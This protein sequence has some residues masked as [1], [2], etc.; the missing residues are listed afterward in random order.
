PIGALLRHPV[1]AEF[2]TPPRPSPPLS[3]P[4]GEEAVTMTVEPRRAIS[5]GDD[6]WEREPS[7]GDRA[8]LPLPQPSRVRA[9]PLGAEHPNPLRRRTHGNSEPASRTA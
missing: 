8:R 4:R 1:K 3:N 5:T 9:A 2:T 7:G 6:S